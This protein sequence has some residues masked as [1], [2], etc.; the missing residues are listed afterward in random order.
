[1]NQIIIEMFPQT[2]DAV[3]IDK[4]FGSKINNDPLMAMLIKGKENDLLKEAKRLEEESKN[5]K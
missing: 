2:K 5:K 3:L 4:W 1:M